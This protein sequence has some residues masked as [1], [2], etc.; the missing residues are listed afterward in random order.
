MNC[1]DN[2]KNVLL[3]KCI[4]DLLVI[5]RK[6]NTKAKLMTQLVK[7][8][9]KTNQVPQPIELLTKQLLRYYVTNK[10]SVDTNN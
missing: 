3:E 7:V 1:C 10:F 8:H 6:I 2:E 9:C 5:N 4:N